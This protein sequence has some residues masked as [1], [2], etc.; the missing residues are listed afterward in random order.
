MIQLS[1]SGRETGSFK[2]KFLN[3]QL[4]PVQVQDQPGEKVG[5]NYIPHVILDPGI[6]DLQLKLLTENWRKL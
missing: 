4:T 5:N 1:S 3:Q 2:K 6:S